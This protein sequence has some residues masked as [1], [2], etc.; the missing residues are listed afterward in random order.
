MP[1]IPPSRT[2]PHR[3]AELIYKHRRSYFPS[4]EKIYNYITSPHPAPL[5]RLSSQLNVKTTT[6]RHINHGFAN[7]VQL[8]KTKAKSSRPLRDP[9]NTTTEL[10]T[11]IFNVANTVPS[12]ALDRRRGNAKWRKSADES[13]V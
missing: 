8:P 1:T 6:F 9:S 10:H 7:T 4:I 13:S 3:K 11:S 2:I 12:L 5:S